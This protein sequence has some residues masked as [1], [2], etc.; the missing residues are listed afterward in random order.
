[1]R[2]KSG[3]IIMIALLKLIKPLIKILVLAIVLGTLGHIAAILIP[4]LGVM[5]LIFSNHRG[6][7]LGVLVA[8]GILR[9]FFRYGEQASN[10]NLAFKTLAHLRHL[11][12][13]KLRDLAPAKL[14][15]KD[16]GDLIA[17]ITHDVELL[18]VFYAHTL[19]PVAI[20]IL[21]C[22]MVLYC[23]SRISVVIT[24][25]TLTSYVLIGVI[26]PLVFSKL[27]NEKGFAYRN[28]MGTL[29]SFVLE[30][31]SGIRDILQFNHGSI[32]FD[33]MKAQ[34][35]SLNEAQEKLISVNI[36]N[37]LCTEI[38]MFTSFIAILVTQ[39]NQIQPSM[40]ILALVM[41]MSSFGP[42]IALSNL[43]SNMHHTL[44][45]GE[46]VL[47]LLEEEPVIHSKPQTSSV[48]YQNLDVDCIHFGYNAEE[49]ISNLNFTLDKNKIVSIEGVSGIGKSTFFKLIMRFWD[50]K[51]GSISISNTN[52]KEIEIQNLRSMQSFMTQDT[53]IFEGTLSSNIRIAKMSASDDE[54]IL[55][56]KK[57][58]L[59]DF[60]MN[61][62][63][64]YETKVESIGTNL[65]SGEKQRLSLA[66]IFL[67]DADLILLD[68]PTSNLDSL[69]EALIL[70]SLYENCHGKTILIASHRTSTLQIASEH[71]CFEDKR[72]KEV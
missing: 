37:T 44:A 69:N 15:T 55:A 12:F 41:H 72:L 28:G 42:V 62:E 48:S 39:M 5:L 36:K 67:H 40:L 45:S 10:H 32:Q 11:V 57:A 3:L 52:I 2:K 19:S 35:Q 58:G 66:R 64:G 7:I 70:K 13:N 20:A 60:I 25:I 50:V 14:E 31:I 61:L 27:G 33:A 23:L 34:T 30:S 56:A 63:A 18:E 38:I 22:S 65:S 17:L 46:R 6:L 16:R 47:T 24:M 21:V 71:F 68:E 49:I 9:G 8:C 1:M 53:D 29:N 43:A 26:F 54:V 59:H 4:V 51:Q